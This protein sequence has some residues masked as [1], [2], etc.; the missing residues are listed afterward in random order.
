MI[1]KITPDKEKAKSIIKL[2]EQ[3]EEFIISI[4]MHKFPTIVAENYYEIIKELITAILLINGI[5]AV[6]ENAHK[7]LIEKFSKY[8][9][10]NPQEIE[11]IDDLRIKRN[12]SLY[13]GKQI[14]L[15]YLEN[16]KEKLVR[17]INTLKNLLNK[18]LF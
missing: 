16:K 8:K 6:G 15:V 13:E 4:N 17:I 3:R 11:I 5:K 10:L 14:E 12:K 9:E 7:E 2:L 18:N 1:I